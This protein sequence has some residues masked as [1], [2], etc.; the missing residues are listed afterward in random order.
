V[1]CALAAELDAQGKSLLDRLDEIAVR[2]GLFESAQR[3][4]VQIKSYFDAREPVAAVAEVGAAR[5]RA[6]RQ[7]GSLERALLG[8]VGLA[9]W[10][11]TA[12]GARRVHDTRRCLDRAHDRSHG[13]P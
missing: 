2:F 5:E 11:R 12:W 9:S 7:L 13:C 10:A 4:V 3:A 8:R 1:L 6:R